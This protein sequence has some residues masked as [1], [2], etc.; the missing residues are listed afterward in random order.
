MANI[1]AH[2]RAGNHG[3]ANVHHMI[4]TPYGAFQYAPSMPRS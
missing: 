2:T 4:Q 3:G 1:E